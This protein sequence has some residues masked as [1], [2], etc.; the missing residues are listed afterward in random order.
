[1]S[2]ASTAIKAKQRPGDRVFSGSA[3]FAGSM[4]LVTLAAVAIFLIVQ[5]IP[6][7]VAD[8][9]D[10]SILPDELLGLR[11]PPP[12]RHRLGRGARAAS[13]PSRSR[14]ASPCSSR[15][16]RRA[17][18][19]RCSATSSTCSPPCP[20]S[21]SA[22]GASACWPRPCSPS[23]PGSSTTSAGSRSSPGPVSGTGRTILT[24]GDR[25]RRHGAADHDRDL[26]RGLPAD[27]R[28][29]RGGGARARRHPL[30]DDPH[31][32]AAVR[33][34]R[35]RLG[36]RAR[37]RPCARRDDGRGDGALGDRAP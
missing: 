23:T 31:G 13:W 11:R 7:F 8:H 27:P 4:I 35:H 1:M 10:A 30:G 19:P 25:A 24:A 33:P 29:P 18:W 6:A 15:T 9:E 26:P 34:L 2:T 16:T 37:P 5:S 28:A 3:V 22:S 14:S 21:C 12:L 17:G 36:G 32:G 20:R